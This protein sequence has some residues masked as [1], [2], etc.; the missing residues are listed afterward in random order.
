MKVMK[1]LPG[2]SLNDILIT[3][4]SYLRECH[5]FDQVAAW[6]PKAATVSNLSSSALQALHFV[7]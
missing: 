6:L 4:L 3:A 5:G 7:F 2:Y 1:L